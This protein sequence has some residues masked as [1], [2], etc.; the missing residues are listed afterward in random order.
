MVNVAKPH[1][2]PNMPLDNVIEVTDQSFQQMV[3][4][5]SGLVLVDFWAP[6][7]TNC[8]QITPIIEKVSSEHDSLVVATVDLD[9]NPEVQRACRIM[10]LPTVLL[11]RD[12]EELS[13]FSGFG[14]VRKMLA[15]IDT[16]LAA[17]QS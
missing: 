10:S 17:A 1:E 14:N 4:E 7:C 2:R 16:H 6:W 9:S 13:R 8:K 5:T 3:G 11:Y 15:E 12:G